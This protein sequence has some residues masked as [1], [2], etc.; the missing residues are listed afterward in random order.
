LDRQFSLRK[1]TSFFEKKEAKKRLLLVPLARLVPQPA[2]S[3]SFLLLFFKKEA[4]AYSRGR[5]RAV[6]VQS[7]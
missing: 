1:A 3:R 5:K 6:A 7:V 4:L 2:V